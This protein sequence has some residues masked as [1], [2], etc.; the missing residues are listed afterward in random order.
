MTGRFLI[1]S[2]SDVYNSFIAPV[3]H[4]VLTMLLKGDVCDG[5]FIVFLVLKRE[6]R[7]ER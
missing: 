4:T 7:N 5:G 1:G 2:S 6:E 3:N